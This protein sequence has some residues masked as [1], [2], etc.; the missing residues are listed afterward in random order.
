MMKRPPEIREYKRTKFK[1]VA[2]TQ[3]GYDIDVRVETNVDD[4][5]RMGCV[6]QLS[7]SPDQW[8]ALNVMLMFAE[9]KVGGALRT[10]V[11]VEADDYVRQVL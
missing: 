11:E 2:S 5:G 7:V 6:G 8:R 9:T 1:L 3:N 4:S 10:S